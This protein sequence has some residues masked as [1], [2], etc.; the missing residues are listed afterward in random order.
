MISAEVTIGT[1]VFPEMEKYSSKLVGCGSYGLRW[2]K[3][4]AHATKVA[5]ECARSLFEGISGKA[6]SLGGPI[7]DFSGF[8]VLDFAS[9]N[10]VFR[11]EPKPGGETFFCSECLRIE[12]N[13]RKNGVNS[14]DIQSVYFRKVDPG[15]A[16]EMG[17]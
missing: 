11:T 9:C 10:T 7:D 13:F 6:E 2:A 14:E 4:S 8:P 12:T 3:T 16:V 17:A 5:P 1:T 15:E